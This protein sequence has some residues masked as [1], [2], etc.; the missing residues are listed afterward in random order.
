LS[1]V[2]SIGPLEAGSHPKIFTAR[3]SF[4][5]PVTLLDAVETLEELAHHGQREAARDMLY[6]LVRGEWNVFDTID[7]R[8]VSDNLSSWS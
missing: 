4:P 3:E 8:G 5:G 1:E 7:L 6:S 2:L